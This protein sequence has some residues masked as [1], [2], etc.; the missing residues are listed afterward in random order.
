MSLKAAAGL[1]NGSVIKAEIA[2]PR[3]SVIIDNTEILCDIPSIG[4]INDHKKQKNKTFRLCGRKYN[5]QK[6]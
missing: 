1:D 5:L 3:D 6:R 4:A 2:I